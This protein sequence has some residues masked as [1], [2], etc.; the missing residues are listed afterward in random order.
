MMARVHIAQLRSCS[1][2]TRHDGR[3]LDCQKLPGHRGHH[4][5]L[6]KDFELV[7]WWTAG[8]DE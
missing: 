7:Q 6:T 4:Y 5:H 3:R 8:E 1:A 2:T